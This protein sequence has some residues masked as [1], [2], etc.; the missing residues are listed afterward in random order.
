MAM[1]QNPSDRSRR[2][3]LQ[4]S[5]VAAAAVAGFRIVTNRCLPQPPFQVRIQK[6][7]CSST[8]TKTPSARVEWLAALSMTSHRKAGGIQV[9]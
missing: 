4:V 5:A 6:T 8:R 1:E 9:G 7:L 3:F 2:S